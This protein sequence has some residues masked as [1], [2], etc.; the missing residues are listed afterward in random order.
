VTAGQHTAGNTVAG[1]R[2]ATKLHPRL[3]LT[4]SLAIDPDTTHTI[5]SHIVAHL[6]TLTLTPRVLPMTSATRALSSEVRSRSPRIRA[7]SSARD[8]KG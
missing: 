4:Q 1:Q 2:R 6:H 3:T 5:L 7:P 8:C